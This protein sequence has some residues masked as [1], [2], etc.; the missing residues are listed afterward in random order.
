MSGR[1]ALVAWLCIGA[2]AAA[3]PFPALAQDDATQHMARRV[4]ELLAAAW[5]RAGVLP[6]PPAD[7]AAFLRRTTLDLTGLV[8]TAFQAQSFLLDHSPNKRQRLIDDLLAS[9][10]HANHLAN[11]WLRLLV[12]QDALAQQRDL[13]RSLQTYL[14]LAFADNRRFDVLVADLLTATG[15]ARDAPAVLFYTARN[16]KPEELAAATSRLF[17]GLQLECAQCHNHPFDRWKQRDFWGLAAFFARLRQ[18][19]T[20]RDTGPPRLFDADTGELTMPNSAEIALPAFPGD[21]TPRST[22]APN[23]R[24]LLALWIVSRDNPYFARASVNRVWAQLFGRGLV[25]PVD[26]LSDHN[27]PSHPELLAELADFFV[28]SGYDLH[29]LYRT[30]AN[31]RAYQLSSRLG[32]EALP[33]PELFSTMALKPM[34][35]EQLF[36]CLLRAT[37]RPVVYEQAGPSSAEV[38]R[39]AFVARFASASP[40]PSEFAAGI[41]QVLTLMNGTLVHELTSPES[42]S[43]IEALEAPYLND[44]Q[45]LDLLTLSVLARWPSEEERAEWLAYLAPGTPSERRQRLADILWAQVNSIEFIFNH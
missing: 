6:A 41:P 30:L 2:M 1:L 28:A 44:A 27:P 4:D 7:D 18:H 12:P 23:R 45:R 8:P 16:L 29:A 10:A 32:P 11:L 3:R 35:A 19:P 42:S 37:R 24:R 22:R 40:R 15:D 31:T 25:E 20:Q 5:E 33:P 14:R 38:L 21:P 26:D 34:T 9:P 43:L 39:D 13:A 17:L 36:D